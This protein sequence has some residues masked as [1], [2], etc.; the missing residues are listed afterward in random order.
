MKVS[1]ESLS[2]S[3]LLLSR[4]CCPLVTVTGPGVSH[5]SRAVRWNSHSGTE[6]R[7]RSFQWSGSSSWVTGQSCLPDGFPQQSYLQSPRHPEDTPGLF[8]GVWTVWVYLHSCLQLLQVCW[9]WLDDIQE[10]P[11]L[12]GVFAAVPVPGP[13]FEAIVVGLV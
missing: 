8:Q 2:A 10:G 6:E 4:W 5:E 1:E 11:V 12:P 9:G 3:V 7:V 13:S